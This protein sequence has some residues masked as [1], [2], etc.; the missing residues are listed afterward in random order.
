MLEVQHKGRF[1]C[2]SRTASRCQGEGGVGESSQT[3]V[4]D[5]KEIVET[6][7]ERTPDRFVVPRETEATVVDSWAD[8]K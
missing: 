8:A 6:A 1:S 3:S 7:M 2:A 5:V 4:G